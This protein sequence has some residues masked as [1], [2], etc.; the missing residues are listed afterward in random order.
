MD[1]GTVIVVAILAI[2]IVA[3]LI[4]FR[5]RIQIAL[6]GP[7]GIGLDVNASNK[8]DS[9]RPGVTVEDAESR[10]GGLSATDNTG[11]GAEVRRVVTEKDI[12]I[13]SGSSSKSDPKA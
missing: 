13:T 4:V 9:V 12:L 8:S 11:H 6:K 5:H 3:V 10:H 2:I 1:N 7:G